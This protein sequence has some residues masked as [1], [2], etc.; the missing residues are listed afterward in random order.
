MLESGY[1]RGVKGIKKK[2][3]QRFSALNFFK[4]G[5]VRTNSFTIL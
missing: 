1:T 3:V 4:N 5:L 2:K